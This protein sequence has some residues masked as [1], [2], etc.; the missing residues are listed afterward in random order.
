VIVVVGSPL[1]LPASTS[2]STSAAGLAHGIAATAAAAGR[3]VQLVGRVGEDPA[4]D[5]TLLALT[6]SGIGHVATLRDPIHPTPAVR[7]PDD[8]EGY[9]LDE[10]ER[11]TDPD[12]ATSLGPAGS[13]T[14]DRADLELA[15][16]Y[17]D[18]FAVLVVAEA[19]EPGAVAVAAEAAAY[20]S[21]TMVLLVRDGDEP[22]VPDDVIVLAAPDSDPDGV[23]ARTVGRF[24]VEL[25]AGHGAEAA[26][27]A[28]TAADGWERARGG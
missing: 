4:G 16:R 18:G 8:E 13:S 10:P 2:E 17:L 14:L 20:A 5:A 23:F 1:H 7:V 26:L 25:D 21:A 12:P 22:S 15:L 11:E 6:R 24:A 27:A 3:D 9:P 19:L 28:A